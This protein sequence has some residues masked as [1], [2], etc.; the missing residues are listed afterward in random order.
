MDFESRLDVT[1]GEY[2]EMIRLK[3]AVLLGCSLQIG[4]LLGGC[5][6]LCG[7]T[8]YDA[9]IH[10]GLAFQ[11]QDDFL[12]TFGNES[13]FGKKIGG[14]I[15]SNKKTFLLIKALQLAGEKQKNELINWFNPIHTESESKISAVREIYED[16]KIREITGEKIKM[17]SHAGIELLQELPA[18]NGRKD[19][20]VNLFRNLIGRIS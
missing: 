7:Q 10:L 11:L 14:D 6:E 20:L 19:L 16:L 4:G 17:F 8:L 18:A 15:E 9:G 5:D 2:L 12:D 13:D 3:T 1:T